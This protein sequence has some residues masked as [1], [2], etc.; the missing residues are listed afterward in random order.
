MIEEIIV[1][2]KIILNSISQSIINDKN[3]IDI[4]EEYDNLNLRTLKL[5]KIIIKEK[6]KIKWCDKFLDYIEFCLKKLFNENKN[7]T[8]N[9]LHSYIINLSI[10]EDENI[11]NFV[12][13]LIC[14][15]FKNIIKDKKDT[16][17]IDV[18]KPRP[19]YLEFTEN[20]VKQKFKSGIT[21]QAT[22][23]GKSFQILK[24]IDL[25]QNLN[26]KN[27]NDYLLLA[28][29][30]DILR[31]MFYKSNEI[32]RIKFDKLKISKIID[33]DNYNIVNF[34][35]EK[36]FDKKLFSKNKPNIIIANMQYLIF[37]DETNINFLN[38]NLKMCI[39]DECH[40]ISGNEIF[41]F[42]EKLKCIHIGF[43]ATPLRN[44][45]EILLNKFY[46]LYGSDNKLNVISSFDIFDGISNE[47]ILPFK[48]YYFNFKSYLKNN[49]ESDDESII[50]EKGL[51][52]NKSIIKNTIMN[53]I[54]KTLPY[55][56]IICWCKTKNLA[57][58]WKTWFDL[59]FKSFKTFLSISGTDFKEND[60]YLEFKHL[61]PKNK[62]EEIKAILFCVG[63][64]REGSDIDFVDC[65]IFLDPVKNR[66]LVVS[67]QTAGRIMRIDK[68]KRKTHAVIIEGYI[69]SE[70]NKSKLNADLIIGYYQKL[71]QISED[72]TNY[73]D[74]LKYLLDNTKL[75][76]DSNEIR[77]KV[78]DN[79]NNDCILNIDMKINDWDSIK[80]IVSIYAKQQIMAKTNNNFDS[81]KNIQ[82][83]EENQLTFSTIKFA[84]INKITNSNIPYKELINICYKEI[85]NQELIFAN[86]ILRL[87][88]AKRDDKGYK[89]FDD[90]QFSIQGADAKHSLL[91][92]IKQCLFNNFSF[93]IVIELEKAGKLFLNND[94]PHKLNTT[95]IPKT[96]TKRKLN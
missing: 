74:K 69:D 45:K 33:I 91:E 32:D 54:V 13:N 73:I 75:N 56:K 29:K 18:Y 47:I 39:F 87:D 79:Y 65:G 11:I 22:G 55:K 81:N 4:L 78:N 15:K 46:K 16:I 10:I 86:T 40:N 35:T 14:D 17:N 19:N 52:Y 30:I 72:K 24:V 60:L 76:S 8:V 34:V 77:I 49:D 2:T 63:R 94:N 85:N 41:I 67:M 20:L 84:K 43:S 6:N 9:D 57:I 50:D 61:E 36:S 82:L 48:H 71:L 12:S 42:L 68:Y 93:E 44:T 80:N 21:V 66:S 92:V 89:Y 58:M 64:C 90:L 1:E 38:K 51:E 88:K 83:V 28:P 70:T 37:M 26:K 5:L 27:Q 62:D 31:D 53:D 59:N 95:N 7:I 96:P 23:T 3:D 25:H